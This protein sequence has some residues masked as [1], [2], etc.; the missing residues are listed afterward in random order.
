MGNT[1]QKLDNRIVLPPLH[2]DVPGV[3]LKFFI[4]PTGSQVSVL[5]S[6]TRNVLAVVAAQ[7]HH[8]EFQVNFGRLFRRGHGVVPTAD[9]CR[10]YEAAE[11]AFRADL[12]R[13]VLIAKGVV[14]PMTESDV[15]DQ[16]WDALVAANYPKLIDLINRAEGK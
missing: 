7:P 16:Y 13:S 15:L 9:E 1:L 3:V 6:N 12:H 14:K 4:A 2:M 5:D 10:A 8:V 11:K